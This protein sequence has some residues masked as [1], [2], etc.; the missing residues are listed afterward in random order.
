[1]ILNED[2]TSDF[3]ALRSRSHEAVLLAFDLIEQD[4]DDIG[5]LPLLARKRRLAKLIGESANA[6][7]FSGHLRG[8]GPA[9]FAHVCRMGLEG[10]VSKRGR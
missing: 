6:I 4:G 3:N 1:M 8:G 2:G 9:V 7:Q 10:I 5:Y